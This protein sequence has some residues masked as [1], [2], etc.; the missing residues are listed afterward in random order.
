MWAQGIAGFDAAGGSNIGSAVGPAIDMGI[1]AVFPNNTLTYL[2]PNISGFSGAGQVRMAQKP[3]ATT[4][5]NNSIGNGYSLTGNYAMGA[6]SFGAGLSENNAEV[7]V[8]TGTVALT[9]NSNAKF[10]GRFF[11]AG[12]DM[13][14]A[15]VNL[16]YLQSDVEGNP[17]A[18]TINLKSDAWGLNGSIPLGQVRLVGG[19][20]SGKIQTSGVETANATMYHLTSFY[21]LSKRTSLFGNYQSTNNDNKYGQGGM[22]FGLNTGSAV[23]RYTVG[24]SSAFTVGIRHTF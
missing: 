20:Y 8:D 1:T 13:G 22:M 5:S 19:Y 7:G 18:A 17:T 10:K 16:V 12:Y 3:G 14:V 2:S 15:K 23:G 6:L 24:S 21:D 4:A 9:G 11:G